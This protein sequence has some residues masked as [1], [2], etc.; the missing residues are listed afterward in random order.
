MSSY[1]FPTCVQVTGH[2]KPVVKWYKSGKEIQADGT[3][4]K[5]QEFKGGYYQLV[6]AAADESDATVYQVRATNS[7]GSVSTTA[8]LE[9][10]G[11]HSSRSELARM[12]LSMVIV[13][14]LS[15]A[16]RS[17]PFQFLPRFTCQRSSKEWEQS[18]LFGAST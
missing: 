10:E 16:M 9:V 3:K 17:L 7:G 11:R 4:I 15:I 18:T 8:N 1:S 5:T 13:L 2:P 12:I 6:I 14:R